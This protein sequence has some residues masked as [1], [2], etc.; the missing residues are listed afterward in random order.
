MIFKRYQQEAAKYAIYGGP[1]YCK[2]CMVPQADPVTALLYVALGLTNESGEV[3]GK[4]KKIMRDS[5]GIVTPE[6]LALIKDELGGV[7]WYAAQLCTELGLDMDQ[8]AR[9]NL[10]KLYGRKQRDTI[11]GDGDSR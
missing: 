4:V 8:V 11:H 10:L 5:N 7:L 9:D 6:T 1:K 3:A 2:H